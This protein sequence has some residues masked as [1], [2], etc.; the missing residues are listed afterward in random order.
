[1]KKYVIFGSIIGIGGWQIYIEAKVAYL[2]ENGW[3]VYVFCPK[4]TWIKE[5]I[6]LIGLVEYEKNMMPELLR[7][8]YHLLPIKQKHVINS[9][10]EIINPNSNDEVII[11]STSMSSSLWGE[12]LA[13]KLNA[14]HFVYLLH[15]H[16][17][18][19]PASF[20][21]FYNFKYER[22]EL[23]GMC[24]QTIP[25]LFH[26]YRNI[27]DNERYDLIAA[28]KNPL[29]NSPES[30]AYANKTL[31][32]LKDCDYI[33]GGFGTLDK[34]HTLDILIEVKKF[35]YKHPDKKVAYI[36]IGS[37][38]A[39]TVETKIIEMSKDCNSLK[40]FFIEEIHPVPEK[41]F[42]EMHVCIGSWGSAKVAALAGAKT[43]LLSSDIDTKPQGIIGYTLTEEPY[44]QNICFEGS[45]LDT[46]EDVLICDKYS[47]Y[48]YI[49]PSPYPDYYIEHKKH[50]DFVENS[51]Q[52]KEYYNMKK[53]KPYNMSKKQHVKKYITML[54]SVGR[55][56][57]YS[58]LY[59]SKIYKLR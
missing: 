4:R 31:Y 7:E 55:I 45:L 1:M 40:V 35:A 14:K 43:I 19:V 30:D 6:K 10:L 25:I 3:E 46:L 36:I 56:D 50:M 58:N 9:M 5:V 17:E 52:I 2:K 23:A 12:I 57:Y 24:E 26:G 34:P 21:E 11:E 59:R 48:E 53:I 16:F 18:N 28:G 47:N 51:C 20:L 42:K 44:L 33:I 49:Q 37:S 15:S 29:C 27:D 54:L 39:G 22:K 38:I 32:K 13:K 8:P 41:L